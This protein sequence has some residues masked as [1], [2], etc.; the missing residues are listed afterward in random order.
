MR[1]GNKGDGMIPNARLKLARHFPQPVLTCN[2]TS[3]DTHVEIDQ[4]RA[5]PE[6][7]HF[8]FQKVLLRLVIEGYKIAYYLVMWPFYGR[9]GWGSY[10]SPGANI[11]NHRFLYLGKHT[12]VNPN[13]T[14]WCQLKT[15]SHV[16]FNPGSC[17]YG[18][19]VMGDNVMIAPNVMIAG[20]NH[21]T[22]LNGVPMTRQPCQA[23]GIIISDDVW[24]GANS[25]VVDGV[26]IAEG[27]VVAAGAVVTKDVP[28]NMIV[29][30]VPARVIR[31]RT[32]S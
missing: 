24:I 19:V 18:P 17:V 21:G 8:I 6:I 13:V 9:L 25:V 14:L 28:R 26:K 10:V 32:A 7:L 29:G 16:T 5:V 3:K 23:D 30:G 22:L 31:P 2:E 15:G 27:A 12:I 20:G 1:G 11:R 4:R